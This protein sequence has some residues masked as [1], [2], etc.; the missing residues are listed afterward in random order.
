LR[1]DNVIK[2]MGIDIEAA[3]ETDSRHLS[4]SVSRRKDNYVLQA[5]KD[6]DTYRKLGYNIPLSTGRRT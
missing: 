1:V 4:K 6:F 5:K 2:N 3:V